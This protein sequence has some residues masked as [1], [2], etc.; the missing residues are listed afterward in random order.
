[1]S[2][3]RKSWREKLM[4]TKDLPKVVEVTPK[5]AGR[6]GTKPG[7]TLL[8]PSPIEVDEVMRKVPRGKLATIDR[9]RTVLADR[10]GAS[11]CCPLTTGIFASIAAK[12]SEEASMEGE[13]DVTPYWRTLKAGGVINDRYPGGV[14]AQ[15]RLLEA[16]GHAVIQKGKRFLVPDYSRHLVEI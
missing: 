12:A 7:D 2:K 10:H 11:I 13:L 3:K 6:W 16:E 1:M 9:I 4:D 5:M 14:E 8:I 15:K